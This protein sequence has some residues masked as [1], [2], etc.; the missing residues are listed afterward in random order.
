MSDPYRVVPFKP[1]HLDLLRAQ[2]VQAAQVSE[3][4]HYA[5]RSPPIV[6]PAMTAFHVEQVL[7]CGG[8]Q[9]LAPGRGV[10]WAVLGANPGRHMRWLHY[11]VKRFISMEPYIRLEASVEEGFPAG[12]RW[13]ELLGFK[14]EGAMPKYGL[15]GKTHLRYGWYG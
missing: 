11:A 14:F 13:V 3:L 7:V 8:I 1:W 2:G 10:C 4:S 15:D 6:G 9:Q 5:G 12:C